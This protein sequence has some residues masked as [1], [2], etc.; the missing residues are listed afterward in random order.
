MPTPA[1]PAS[2]ANPQ[3][4]T[5]RLPGWLLPSLLV[6]TGVL[7]SL[8]VLLAV[9][10]IGA[11]PAPDACAPTDVIAAQP[12]LTAGG[13]T[14]ART[15][16][17]AH[18]NLYTGLDNQ[19]FTADL[20]AVVTGQ[21]DLVTLNETYTRSRDQLTPPG[22]TAWRAQAPRDARETPVL[23]RTDTWTAIAHGTELLHDRPVQWGTRSLNW[24]TL[25]AA[26]GSRVSVISA[27]ASP[28]PGRDGLLDTFLKRLSTVVAG[29]KSSGPVL[30]GADLNVH[31]PHDSPGLDGA[32][33]WLTQQLTAADLTS[34]YAA[35]GEPTGG[36]VT[37]EGGGTIDYLLSSGATAI[38]HETRDLPHSNHRLLT[39]TYSLETA[40]CAP[41]DGTVPALCPAS[42]GAAEAGLTHDALR[43][44]RCI[45]TVFGPHIVGGVGDRPNA[46]DHPA[47]RA[48]DVMIQNWDTT[49]GNNEGWRI[50]RWAQA[51]ATTLRVTYVIF[52]KRIWSTA[53]AAEGWRPYTHPT[54]ASNPTLD[55]RDHV[56]VSVIGQ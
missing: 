15:V 10:V 28:G 27:H 18:A 13:D 31:Y 38:T 20:T 1:Q 51:N 29:L 3:P 45:L 44:M 2:P 49:A 6:L 16:T 35:L 47:G 9:T 22:Y 52:D 7:T 37:G 25:Q 34:S 24:V 33:G 8:P 12:D 53:R 23:W 55:H 4:A 54:G 36:W 14:A 39:A 30:V 56:H 43:V 17:L 48:V 32:A 41:V 42:G 50:A 26:D 40:L 19:Q 5:R 46:S 11:S 21:P